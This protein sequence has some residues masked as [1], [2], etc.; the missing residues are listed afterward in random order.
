MHVIENAKPLPT[1]DCPEMSQSELNQF[2]PWYD[3][4]KQSV[5]ININ[6][7]IVSYYKRLSAD[8]GI[9]FQEL[10]SMFLTQC[11]NEEK[12]PVFA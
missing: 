3:R 4:E 1:D 7:D 6:V 10:M 11:A 5:T 9:P 2:R 8:T 12:K